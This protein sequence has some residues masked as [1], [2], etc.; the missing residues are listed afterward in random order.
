MLC[1]SM[2]VALIGCGA[3]DIADDESLE[4]F[5]D[6]LNN[7]LSGQDVV[8]NPTEYKGNEFCD[9]ISEA[10]YNVIDNAPLID[11][12]SCAYAMR[13][14]VN[15]D[16]YSMDILET[17]ELQK[18]I[19][20]RYFG[21]PTAYY[22]N[23]TNECS[24][25]STAMN[26]VGITVYDTGV[27][28]IYKIMPWTFVD[29]Y[30]EGFNI[31]DQADIEKMHQ[32]NIITKEQLYADYSDMSY[33][34]LANELGSEGLLLAVKLWNDST[35]KQVPSCEISWYCPEED[36]LLIYARAAYE[37]IEVKDRTEVYPG[38]WLNI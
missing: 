32:K 23:L 4:A 13:D 10:Y 31:V 21:E 26:N 6:M 30:S 7:E 28:F 20:K 1:T 8:G 29:V 33:E 2:M 37:H 36:K 9:E 38:S 5:E 15:A 12:M 3:N 35:D 24:V 19:M 25:Y 14:M 17:R 22:M 34:E 18:N 16:C 27:N 11:H